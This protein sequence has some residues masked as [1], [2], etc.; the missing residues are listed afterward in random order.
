[1]TL[2]GEELLDALEVVLLRRLQEL[3]GLADPSQGPRVTPKLLVEELLTQLQ[4][5][6]PL[7]LLDVATDA[8]LGAVRVNKA[9]PVL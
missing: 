6:R 8:V 5:A 2:Q 3:R 4:A 1:M 9:Q 7:L